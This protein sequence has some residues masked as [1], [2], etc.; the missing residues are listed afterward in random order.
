MNN[1]FDRF[2]N[3]LVAKYRRIEGLSLSPEEIENEIENE[4]EQM[5]IEPLS[6]HEIDLVVSSISSK[7]HESQSVVPDLGWLGAI[8]T[9]S[10]QEGVFQLN[11][12]KG[13]TSEE[14]Q[15]K[16]DELRKKALEEDDTDDDMETD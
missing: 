5:Q 2:W 3:E 8:D 13:K 14:M 16:L 4:I 9:S 10:V 1:D 12:N 11:R 15:K 7:E 6:E